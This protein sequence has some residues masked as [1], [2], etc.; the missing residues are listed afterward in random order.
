MI[1]CSVYDLVSRLIL[2]F[3]GEEKQ[4]L[5]F[6]FIKKIKKKFQNST[7]NAN[8]KKI[9]II[10]IIRNNHLDKAIDATENKICVYTFFSN[11]NL[12]VIFFLELAIMSLSILL[13]S[14]S[15]L[16]IHIR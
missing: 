11:K 8:Y 3:N 5:L 7:S 4:Y 2:F 16:T 12:C 1:I 6:K 15:L 9:K 13:S 10:K 14:T